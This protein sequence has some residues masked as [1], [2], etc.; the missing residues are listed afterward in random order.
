MNKLLTVLLI[1]RILR[2]EHGDAI[3]DENGLAL[4]Y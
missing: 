1:R 3:T 4:F 2:D